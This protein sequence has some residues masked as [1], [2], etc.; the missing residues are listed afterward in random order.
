MLN[1]VPRNLIYPAPLPMRTRLRSVNQVIIHSYELQS[2]CVAPSNFILH[3]KNLT[4][5]PDPGPK[6]RPYRGSGSDR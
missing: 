2:I 5:G 6:A 4:S 1:G 3:T